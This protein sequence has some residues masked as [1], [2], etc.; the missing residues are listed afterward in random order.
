MARGGTADGF[1]GGDGNSPLSE[2]MAQRHR[3]GSR[4]E[5]TWWRRS[6]TD[7][8]PAITPITVL[9]TTKL[10]GQVTNLSQVRLAATATTSE[11]GG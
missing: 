8:A 7:T 5:L 3:D 9:L 11:T 2:L 6:W 4:W 10:A 1:R